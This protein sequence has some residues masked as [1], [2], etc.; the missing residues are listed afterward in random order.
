[1]EAVIK[2]FKG[3]VEEWLDV[4]FVFMTSK[5]IKALLGG[6]HWAIDQRKVFLSLSGIQNRVVFE[7]SKISI[8]RGVA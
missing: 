6:S 5:K 1:M 2:Y 3:Y 7:R 4:F 8:S